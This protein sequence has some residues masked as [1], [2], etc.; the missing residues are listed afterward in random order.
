MRAAVA[1]IDVVNSVQLSH[2]LNPKDYESYFIEPLHKCF[3][4]VLQSFGFRS[5]K[6]N[7]I[8]EN[9]KMF[10]DVPSWSSFEFTEFD[11]RGDQ[12]V[13][14]LASQDHAKD[15]ETVTRIALET[16]QRWGLRFPNDERW[17]QGM[18]PL[19]IV[20][21]IHWGPIMVRQREFGLRG[22]KPTAE[23]Y[24]IN[25]AKRVESCARLGK[26]SHIM[27]SE[28]AWPLLEEVKTSYLFFD[29]SKLLELKGIGPQF[30]REVRYYLTSDVYTPH[31]KDIYAFRSRNG[32]HNLLAALLLL[33]DMRYA[34]ERDIPTSRR[35]LW[36]QIKEAACFS[37]EI[38]HIVRDRIQQY[39]RDKMKEEEK[40]LPGD[41]VQD[42]LVSSD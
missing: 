34:G 1:F 32:V 22:N 30:L 24:A 21:G 23:G 27:L 9:V 42:W 38:Q 26:Y 13:V 20:G 16:E 35:A 17:R 41:P 14:I 7:V 31:A 6:E 37:P 8:L 10:D 29:E 28:S 40:P 36:E 12:M 15:V 4:S 2:A 19:S 5:E 33:N 25:Y 11:I 18:P 39:D 3:T